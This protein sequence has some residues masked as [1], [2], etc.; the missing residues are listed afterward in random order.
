MQVNKSC[1]TELTQAQA[2]FGP[3]KQLF[4]IFFPKEKKELA[5]A[6]SACAAAK[7]QYDE[8][9]RKVNALKQKIAVQEEQKKNI[10]PQPKPHTT[11]TKDILTSLFPGKSADFLSIS[12]QL[13]RI[14]RSLFEID[15]EQQG[16][17]NVDLVIKRLT[18]EILMVKKFQRKVDD[19]QLS[20]RIE[21]VLQNMEVTLAIIQ[22]NKQEQEEE[23][24]KILNQKMKK[25]KYGFSKKGEK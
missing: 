9:L 18:S 6:E 16:N 14:E 3:L 25:M 24:K 4:S 23:A 13:S 17:K 22:K 20:K 7:M 1:I 21:E 10:T 15:S 2:N 5:Q 8:Q 19:E 12:T 11:L